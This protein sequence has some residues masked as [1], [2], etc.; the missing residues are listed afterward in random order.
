[1][2][3][4]ETPS[5]L[6]LSWGKGGFLEEGEELC[7]CRLTPNFRLLRWGVIPNSAGG[8]VWRVGVTPRGGVVA[9]GSPIGKGQAPALWIFT[10]LR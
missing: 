4:E 8:R 7:W 9:G 5:L 6:L 1:M 3:W 2:K 10:L